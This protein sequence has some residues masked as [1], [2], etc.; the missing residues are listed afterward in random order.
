MIWQRQDD[1]TTRD[2]YDAITY[3]YDSTHDFQT[4]W[5]LPDKKE[6]ASIVNYETSAPSIDLGAFPSTESS[7]Y[8]SSMSNAQNTSKAWFV[9]FKSGFTD[10]RSNTNSYYVRCVRGQVSAS[11]FE[12]QGDDTVLDEKTLLV[13][14]QDPT[15]DTLTWEAAIS[16][17]DGLSL[18][19]NSDWRLPNAREL[20][21]IT[22][23]SKSS[24]PA[25]DTTYFEDTK[26]SQ[27][28]S[29]TT[30]SIVNMTYAWVVYFNT[31]NVLNSEKTSYNYVRCVRAGQ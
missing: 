1:D 19:G 15:D 31:G 4:D 21:S 25:I 6:L 7:Q 3:C 2:W 16:Y 20:E 30:K 23:D 9:N 26:S 17:C 22:D 28:W 13:W 11:T 10:N 27:Y 18:A 14:Q 24:A 8:W 29:S 12:D 5:R